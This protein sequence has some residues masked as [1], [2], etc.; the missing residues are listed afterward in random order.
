MNREFDTLNSLCYNHLVRQPSDNQRG[1]I[2]AT[3][4]RWVVCDRYGNDV[5][6]THERWDHIVELLNHP[7]ML[8]YEKHLKE[9]V[10]S[11]RRKQDTL[12]PK[13]YRYVKP[14]M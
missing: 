9:T 13:K 11:G 12:N 14:F 8:A 1:N 7:E 4:K 3:G 2:V 5:Y 6:L 10:E